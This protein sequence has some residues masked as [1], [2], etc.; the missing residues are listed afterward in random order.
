MEQDLGLQKLQI[1]DPVA[2]PPPPPPFK[3]YY[4]TSDTVHSPPLPPG[5]TIDGKA[6]EQDD[7][8]EVSTPV[9]ARPVSV[10]NLAVTPRNSARPARF[11]KADQ[12]LQHPAAAQIPAE[13][14]PVQRLHDLY[15]N[16]VYIE[17]YLFKKN[18]TVGKRTMS[19]EQPW[20]KSYVEL[21]GPVLTVWDAETEEG[22][23]VTPQYI[24]IADSVIMLNEHGIIVLRTAGSAR[25]LLDVA[26]QDV[27]TR[28]RWVRAMR[29]SCFEGARI[30]EIY[31][32]KFIM[33]HRVVEQDGEEE[34]LLAKPKSKMEGYLQVR[35][36][37]VNEW[38]KYWVVVSDRRDEK[39]LFGKKSVP[40]RGQLMFYETKKAKQPIMTIVNVVQAYTLYPDSPQLVDLS[41][42][43]KVDGSIG[44]V[45][46][47]T[48]ESEEALTPT[49]VLMMT[50]NNS[51][52]V[53]WLIGV[54]DAFKLYGR[55]SQLLRDPTNT[56]S[57][58]FGEI[59]TSPRLF[60]E[61]PE[62]E[63]VDV[64][65][66]SARQNN[67]AF[68]NIMLNKMRQ[69]MN[70]PGNATPPQPPPTAGGMGPRAISMPQIAGNRGAI[71]NPRLR[72]VSADQEPGNVPRASMMP[73]SMSMG[74]LST[75]P[76]S[77]MQPA[78]QRMQPSR[79][80][81]LPGGGGGRGGKVVYNSDDS[82]EEED[83][84]AEEDSDDDDDSV[85]GQK[86]TTT[87]SSALKKPSEATGSSF[88]LTLP[89]SE[90][91]SRSLSAEVEQLLKAREK[92]EELPE[93][94]PKDQQDKENKNTKR[95][96]QPTASDSEDSDDDDDDRNQ[97]NSD[98]ED[99]EDDQESTRYTPH[100]PT[101]RW[102]QQPPQ[103]LRASA[104]PPMMGQQQ[105]HAMGG[106]PQEFI[107]D[108]YPPDAY[109]MPQ[110][111]QPYHYP[112]MVDEDG[113]IIPQLGE[114]FANPH[115]LLGSVR[116]EH[117]SARDMAEHAKATGQPLVDIPYKPPEPRAGLVGMISQIEQ[118]KKEHSKGRLLEQERERMML[119][120]ERERYLMEQRQSMMVSS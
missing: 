24:N 113:P 7:M 71:R 27:R 15:R 29:L 54:Y 98:E 92:E 93:S 26:D 112:A 117:I 86:T 72:T 20:I 75:L 1:S 116:P 11:I 46:A 109:G 81:M 10:R 48:E 23:D 40:S 74:R 32:K 80:T 52:L 64:Q 44:A 85:F 22:T 96:V 106:H 115:S 59:V 120:R 79:N 13:L 83:N 8:S 55:P 53:E 25:Y 60:L 42:L 101:S 33:R 50:T 84:D 73:S 95:R 58:S 108:E 49:S 41:T 99:E 66:E 30:H 94:P 5:I 63:A 34:D 21:S 18:E 77:P 39:K 12:P 9:S 82:E 97:Q 2:A 14:Q 61:V 78:G 88:S 57:L 70:R 104:M 105:Q 90:Q 28:D 45:A 47:A 56:S 16:K 107:D 68:V 89:T 6:W 31:T 118:T 119:E 35:F 103:N 38:Q 62:L 36:S 4:S 111:Q 91:D 69:H 19:E 76:P 87:A 100:R 37:G 65:T 51:E 67:E 3:E 102:P 110:Q 114:N 43:I 17:G